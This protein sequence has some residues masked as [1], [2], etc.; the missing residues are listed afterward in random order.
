MRDI[1]KMIEVLEA[2]WAGKP[3]EFKGVNEGNCEWQEVPYPTWQFDTYDYRV[4]PEPP[5]PK[6]WILVPFGERNNLENYTLEPLYALRPSDQRNRWTGVIHVLEV[7]S[8][9]P[10]RPKSD[11]D[12][13]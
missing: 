8:V 5:K 4:K 7:P 6:E 10:K 1:P 12:Q 3:I 13:E 9:E 2:V 11:S